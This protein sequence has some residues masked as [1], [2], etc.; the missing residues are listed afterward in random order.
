MIM[1]AKITALICI[2][3]IVV[4]GNGC[5]TLQELDKSGFWRDTLSQIVSTSTSVI[6]SR[7]AKMEAMEQI[8]GEQAVDEGLR[9][10]HSI[11]R[12]GIYDPAQ[13]W[14]RY[15]LDND[16]AAN[17]IGEYQQFLA[18]NNFSPNKRL[19]EAVIAGVENAK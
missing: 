12:A 16:V 4:I 13:I 18:M 10:L 5:S 2:L 6:I 9:L 11:N 14:K 19:F 1:F 8:D 3:A 15:K 7:I 17:A